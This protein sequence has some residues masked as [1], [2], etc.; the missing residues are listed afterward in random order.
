MLEYARLTQR[1]IRGKTR[2]EMDAD[3]VVLLA[4][5]KALEVVGEAARRLSRDPRERHPSVPW[6]DIGGMRNWLVHRYDAIDP[7]AVWKA[8]H[9][10]VP[11]L[12][13]DLERILVNETGPQ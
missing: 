11:V 12:I 5:R 6:V 1:L 10:D 13:G 4:L 3:E 9:D 8:L 2:G 7:D